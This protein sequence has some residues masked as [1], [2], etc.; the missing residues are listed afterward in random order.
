MNYPK[1]CRDILVPGWLG[2]QQMSWMGASPDPPSRGAPATS[3]GF[4]PGLQGA[5]GEVG[6]EHWLLSTAG[7]PLL[8][9]R[10]S[11]LL[12]APWCGACLCVGLPDWEAAVLPAFG[13]ALSLASGSPLPAASRGVGAASCGAG[14]G[15]GF[16]GPL[17][18]L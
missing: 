1:G 8:G 11:T 13:A 12:R 16:M 15:S 6:R 5:V 3:L 7:V 18:M 17:G 14:T 10:L 9:Q 4:L 2:K